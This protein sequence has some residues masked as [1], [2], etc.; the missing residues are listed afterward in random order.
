MASAVGL[1]ML[2]GSALQ[3]A[4]AAARI[5]RPAITWVDHGTEVE[6][7]APFGQVFVQKRPVGI[8]V[9]ATGRS[10]HT[11]LAPGPD[12]CSCTDFGFA[13]PDGSVARVASWDA[14]QRGNT[15]RGPVQLSDGTTAQLRL[16]VSPSTGLTVVLMPASGNPVLPRPPSWQL[17]VPHEP[18]EGIY[19]LTERIVDDYDASELVPAEVGS[20]DRT[21]E[22]VKMYVTPTISGYAPFFQSSSG[23]GVLV[24]GTMPGEYDVAKSDPTRT[25]LTFELPPAGPTPVAAAVR[26]FV[27]SHAGI[28]DQYTRLTGRPVLPPDVVFTHWRGRDEYPVGPPASWHG[29]QINATV[30]RDLAA[31]E[32]HHIPPGIF[33]FDRPW[34]VGSEG[35][36]DFRFDPQRFPNVVA[37]LKEMRRAGWRIQVWISPWVLDAPGQYAREHGYLAPRSQRALDL[38]NPDAVAWEQQ[39]IV[40]FLRGPEGRYVDGVFLDRGDEGDVTSGVNDVYHDG[41]TGR[42]VHNAYPV[43]YERMVREALLRARP[44][45]HGRAAVWM[46][47]RPA[48]TGS[49]SLTMRWPGDTHSREGLLIPE[50]E[51]TSPST[52]KGLRSY[53]ISMQRAAFMGTAYIGSD[54]GGYSDWTDKDLYA[55]WVEVSALS[56][57]MRFHGKGPAPWDAGPGGTV[58]PELLAIYR[59]YV[60]LHHALAPTLAGLAAVAH[61]RGT[62]IVRPLVFRWNTQRARDAWDEWMIGDDML[63]APV[64]RSGERSRS[65]WLPPGRWVSAWSPKQ[66]LRG[67]EE[68]TVDVPLDQV[69]LY[70]KAGSPLLRTV[71]RAVSR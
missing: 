37:M 22:T 46:I 45:R 16:D 60:A 1:S 53:L 12:G 17:A 63:A 2:V 29:I 19:G 8:A 5:A 38:T 62:P 30:A 65:V 14:T 27:G 24:D 31:Y 61:A 36:G 10:Q 68:L 48:Y 51:E 55:R 21:G 54:T 44:A 32:Q 50:V 11:L 18:G 35:Y 34:A 47:S 64:W 7:R 6:V 15:L 39:R 28:L 43:L 57:L 13:K 41:R 3:P 69:P 52:D 49:Q 71:V 40:D 4:P 23:Y 58:D 70:V 59:R 9:R 20:L 42:E 56:P 33:H 26:V 67:P 25:R 66:V